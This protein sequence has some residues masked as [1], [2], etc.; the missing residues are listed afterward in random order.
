[1][2]LVWNRRETL[3]TL[4]GYPLELYILIRDTPRI[5]LKQLPM[6]F[7]SFYHNFQAQPSNVA[8]KYNS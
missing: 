4:G 7:N 1:M 5:Y 2:G 3:L 8:V 6:A